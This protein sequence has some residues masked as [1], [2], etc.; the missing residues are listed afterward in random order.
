MQVFRWIWVA[1]LAAL[2]VAA[3]GST[4]DVDANEIT[5]S[6]TIEP[7]VQEKCQRCHR[8]GGIA[9]FALVSYRDVK[10]MGN[11]AKEKVVAREMPPWGA[12]DDDACKVQHDF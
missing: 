7:L 3:C 10:R 5:F 2:G 11:L 12:F 1:L 8:E 4:E 9:P 6:K